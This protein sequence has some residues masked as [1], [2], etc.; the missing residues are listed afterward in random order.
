MENQKSFQTPRGTLAR[1]QVVHF[2][3]ILFNM[4][5]IAVAVMIASVLS[6]IVPFIYYLFLTLFLLLTLFT[7]LLNETFNSMWSGGETLVT[8]AEVLAQSWKYTVPIVAVMSVASIVCLAL[9]KQEKHIA[10]IVVSA[11]LFVLSIGVLIAK[12]I[13]SGGIA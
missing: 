6:F 12:L 3:K 10:R 7:A 4:Q 1:M 5:F 8:I 2:G 13:N 9:D 11:I